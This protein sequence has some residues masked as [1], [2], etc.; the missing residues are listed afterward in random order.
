MGRTLAK[1]RANPNIDF[2]VCFFHHCAYS[3]TLSH[4]SDGGVRDAWCAL[5]DRYQVDLVLQGHN[6]VFERTD[7]I[8][9]GRPTREAGDNST[10]D[11]ETDGTVYYTV[12]SAGRPATTFSP[13]SRRVTAA[14]S[15][16]TRWYPIA[17]SGRPMAAS[18][19]RQSPGRG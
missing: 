11:P 6:H 2:I 16:Q 14:G 17:L 13:A 3:T 15:F 4:A 19:P 5:F 7:P 1:Y 10:V 12:G 18:M 8:R 9:A